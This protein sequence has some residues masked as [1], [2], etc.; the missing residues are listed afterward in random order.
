LLGLLPLILGIAINVIADN[1]FHQVKT[2]VRPF[3]ESSVLV[4]SGPFRWSR[5]PMYLGFVLILTG[6]GILLGSLTPFA[7]VLAFAV[8]IDRRF[9]QVEEHMLAAEFGA[10]WQA[11]IERTRRWL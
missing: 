3:E 2:T 9:I 4:T 11:Y 8:L 10:V 1:L 6:I 5:N 7:I